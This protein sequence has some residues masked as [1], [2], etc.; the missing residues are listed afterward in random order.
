MDKLSERI[1]EIIEPLINL[2]TEF[3]ESKYIGE[4]CIICGFPFD[5]EVREKAVKKV[6]QSLATFIREAYPKEIKPETRIATPLCEISFN[7]GRIVGHNTCIQQIRKN[8]EG[9]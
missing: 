4:T 8:L 9:E 1:E 7:K 6:A 2:P 5:R 3:A